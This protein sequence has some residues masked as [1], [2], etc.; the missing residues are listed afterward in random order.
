MQKYFEMC[1]SLAKKAAQQKEVPIGAVIVQNGKII[2]KCYN[3]REKKHDIMAHAEIL[4][5]KK[6]SKKLKRWNLGDCDLYVSLKPC[7]MC[8]TVINQSRLANVYYLCEKEAYK[9]E[10]DKVVYQNV[11]NFELLKEYRQLLSSFFHNKR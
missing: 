10:F 7:K 2:A 8:E 11:E 6:A 3:L 9:K 4:A 1:I 5:I